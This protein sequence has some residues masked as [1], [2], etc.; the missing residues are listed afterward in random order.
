MKI[1][2]WGTHFI[3]KGTVFWTDGIRFSLWI[4]GCDQGRHLR[5]PGVFMNKFL[6]KQ[7][8][9]LAQIS[10]LTLNKVPSM[11]EVCIKR[12]ANKPNNNDY[13]AADILNKVLKYI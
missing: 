5:S 10:H 11:V 12:N 2:L 4:Q 1:P 9:F 8:V 6:R 7:R 13:Q 3:P